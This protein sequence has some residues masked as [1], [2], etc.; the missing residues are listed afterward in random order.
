[1]L[2]GAHMSVAGGVDKAILRGKEVGCDVIQLFTKNNNQWKSKPLTEEDVW[3]FKKN[4]SETGIFPF[5]SHD[6]YLINFAAPDAEI[7]KKSMESFLDEM[8][9]AEMLGIPGLVFHPGSHVGS[10][11]K[12]GIKQIADSLRRLL[13]ER[14]QYKVKLLLETTAGQGSSIGYKFEHLAEIME[15]VNEPARLGVCLDTC[16]VFA[17]GY[18]ISHKKGYEKTFKAFDKIVGLKFLN[19]FHLNDSKKGLGSRV[20]RHEHIGKGELGLKAFEVLM[21]DDR[22]ETIPMALETPKGADMKEDRINLKVLRELIK[23]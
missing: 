9:R 18:D 4:V 7:H 16:H 6:A 12:A 13:R 23:R 3:A 14:P 8:D 2:L 15:K 19:A 20:D 1:M 10:G 11:E 5:A 17:A 22:F 21:N